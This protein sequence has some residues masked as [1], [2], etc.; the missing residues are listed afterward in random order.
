M[1]ERTTQDLVSV[2]PITFMAHVHPLASPLV[3]F[4]YQL[5]E[6]RLIHDEVHHSDHLLRVVNHKVSR[7]SPEVLRIILTSHQFVD[8]LRAES[9]VDPHRRAEMFPQRFQ[10]ILTQSLQVFHLYLVRLIFHTPSR[11]H[12][13]VGHLLKGEMFCQILAH[14]T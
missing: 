12:C 14:N 10:H 3:S 11:P 2:S 8:L 4:Q 6:V 7:L 13:R 5:V 1:A 9:R